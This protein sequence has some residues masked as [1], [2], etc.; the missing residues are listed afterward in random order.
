MEI[1]SLKNMQQILSKTS[2]SQ[3]QMDN[4]ANCVF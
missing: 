1:Y 2:L 4:K 3:I